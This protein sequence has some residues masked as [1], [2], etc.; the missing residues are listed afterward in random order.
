MKTKKLFVVAFMAI[1]A[2]CFMSCCNEDKVEYLP[3]QTIKN[4][5]LTSVL[6]EKGYNFNADGKLEM[7]DKVFQTTSL[8]LS[9]TGLTDLK[10]LSVF[11]NLNE[12]KLSNNNYGAVFDFDNIPASIT[13]VDLSGNNIYDF[14]HLVDAV[15]ENNAPLV[16]SV[17][18][19]KK[20]VLPETAKYNIEDV[21]VLYLT[22]G[23]EVDLQMADKTGKVM[24]YNTI[25]EIP[26][27]GLASYLK[28]IYGS[29]FVDDTHIDISKQPVLR[30]QGESIG[31]AY[32]VDITKIKSLEGL[33]YFINNP[34]SRPCKFVVMGEF[35]N[36]SLSYLMPRGNAAALIMPHVNIKAGLDCSKATNLLFLDLNGCDG[37][38]KLDL[39]HTR[40]FNITDKDLPLMELPFLKVTKCPNLEE[41]LLPNKGDVIIKELFIG[42]AP[43]LKTLDLSAVST[44]QKLVL[45]TENT[46][47]TLPNITR[48]VS[49]EDENMMLKLGDGVKF[50]FAFSK[51]MKE[52][53][54]IKAYLEKYKNKVENP[55]LDYDTKKDFNVSSW[56]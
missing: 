40:M 29:L 25:R 38:T 19:I 48:V 53:E 33:E 7:N 24:P 32:P 39:Q 45:G 41:V 28:S 1:T 12:I 13:S 34:F 17:R 55:Y 54:T 10:D 27:A 5:A 35:A 43:K 49:S 8:D 16:K 31:L 37:V 26:D 4:T 22:K 51:K 36:N 46:M 9:N 6:K 21:V 42:N 44:I 56:K 15:E 47:L 50:G 18:P 52:N 30:E 23:K 14:E 11:P 20:L 3:P 2:S